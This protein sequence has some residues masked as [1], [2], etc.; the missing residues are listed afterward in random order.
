MFKPHSWMRCRWL[1][2]LLLLA[3]LTVTA[4]PPPAAKPAAAPDLEAQ[5]RAL[6]LANAAV[7]GVRSVAVE[8]ARSIE[9]LG[10]ERQGSGVV[11]SAD[12]LV[13]TVGYLILEADQVELVLERDRIVPARVIAYDLASGFGLLQ[14]LTPLRLPPARMG[15]PNAMSAEE[16]LMIAS[17]GEDGDLSLARMVS[18]RPYFGYWE[19]QVDGALFTAPPRTDH[20]GAGLFNARGELMGI[21]SLVVLDALGPNEPRM[22]GNMFIPVDLLRA[23]LPELRERG[24][25]RSSTRAWLG[26]N[27]VDLDGGVRIVRITHDSPA[28]DAGLLPGDRILR[29]DGTPVK[30]L[31]GFYKTLWRDAPAEREVK[32]LVVRGEVEQTVALQSQD[33]M[34]TL[35]RAR[36]I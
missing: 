11:I 4:A 26:L 8:D 16:P 30:D 22:A 21:G 17:G 29:I 32:L 19:Y 1:P 15:N 28:E 27:C 31:A 12:G 9:N 10:R 18:R 20:S 13:V 34:K 25:T 7:V 6:A 36:G 2:W 3:T 33:R 23:I 14:A 24:A 35:R 5:A